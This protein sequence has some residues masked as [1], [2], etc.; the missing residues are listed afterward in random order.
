MSKTI[1]LSMFL[2]FV[3]YQVGSTREKAKWRKALERVSVVSS[4]VPLSPHR[5][6][7]LLGS[8]CAMFL[9]VVHSR[10]SI[11]SLQGSECGLALP[12]SPLGY[13]G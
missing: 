7:F 4:S 5:A 12:E 8:L 10:N 2:P 11:Y 3:D 9:E 1:L 13:S 6:A